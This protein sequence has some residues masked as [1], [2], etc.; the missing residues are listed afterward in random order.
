MDLRSRFLVKPGKK[1]GLSDRDPAATPG[2]PGKEDGEKRL[3]ENLK[4]L[5]ELQF[6]LYAEQKRALLVV[7]QAMDTGGKDG[8]IRH[9]FTGFNPQNIRVASFKVP[10]AE[11]ASHDFLWRIHRAVPVRGEV[12]VFNRSHYEDVVVVRVKDLVE[13]DVW[14]KRYD[15]INEFE[16]L[17]AESGTQV[18]KLFLHIGKDE[19]KAR[20]QARLDDPDRR[21][22]F[23]LGDL[24]ERK[25]WDR[26]MEAYE[27]ALTRCS[28]KHAPWYVVPANKKWY[29]NLAASQILLEHLEEMKPKFPVSSLDPRKIRIV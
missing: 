22:K 24:E 25:R 27:D 18:V 16:E 28:T 13:K 21:W 26:Y 6:A 9:V 20:L 11:E 23:S 2:S 15:R 10:T 1:A 8:V 5:A 29:R 7:L 12:G 14:S 17:L 19:Q 3:R 4:R